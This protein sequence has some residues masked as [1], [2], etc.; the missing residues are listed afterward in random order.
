[1]IIDGETIVFKSIPIFFNLEKSG[2]KNHTERWLTAEER[3]Q[4]HWGE[5]NKIR[6]CN[7]KTG[8]SFDRELVLRSNITSTMPEEVKIRCPQYSL[9]SLTWKHQ[10]A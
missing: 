5:I 8:E 4:V 2:V 9:F 7:T 6:I 3:K 10:E 1:M